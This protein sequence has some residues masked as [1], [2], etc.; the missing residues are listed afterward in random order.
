MQ[1]IR[2]YMDREMESGIETCVIMK[3][4]KGQARKGIELPNQV[5]YKTLGDK[6]NYEYLGILEVH[7]VKQ[8]VLKDKENNTLG[9][10][11]NLLKLNSATG[12]SSKG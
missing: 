3:N 5:R 1:K 10:L 2:L 6:E 4:G 12:I 8:A 11:E 9:E 7:I